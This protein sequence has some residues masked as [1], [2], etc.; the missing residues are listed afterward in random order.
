[1]CVGR[2]TMNTD[3]FRYFF[4]RT[5][6]V[7]CACVLATLTA[8]DTS[9]SSTIAPAS[10]GNPPPTE[11]HSDASAPRDSAA[12][13]SEASVAFDGATEESDGGVGDNDSGGSDAGPPANARIFDDFESYAVGAK[14]GTPWN[15]VTSNQG[16]L[17]IDTTHVR[18]G[19]KAIK[20]TIPAMAGDSSALLETTSSKLFPVPDQK[21]YG[22]MMIYSPKIPGSRHWT[23]IRG[24]G[25]ILGGTDT[26]KY[27][28]GI[29]NGNYWQSEYFKPNGFLDYGYQDFA[30]LTSPP[31]NKWAC[32]EWFMDGVNRILRLWVDSVSI[33]SASVTQEKNPKWFGPA[34]NYVNIGIDSYNPGTSIKN[35]LWVDDVAFGHQRIGCP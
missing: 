27:G 5:F 35:E 15:S 7:A 13:T 33:D 9:E 25:P 26:V 4:L 19:S 18:S 29:N 3:P 17:A 23:M 1:M 20:F 14:P 22:R 2:A 31:E 28:F 34:F 16:S 11:T 21:L 10:T 12:A 24:T 32:V 30:M 8:C 6:R